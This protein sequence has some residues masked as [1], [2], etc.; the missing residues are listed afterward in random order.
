L[1]PFEPNWLILQRIGLAAEADITTNCFK[2]GHDWMSGPKVA[3]TPVSFVKGQI[4]RATV[5]WSPIW[6]EGASISVNAV[7]ERCWPE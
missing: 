3:A 1:F 4:V 2:W 7:L 5:L 6:R